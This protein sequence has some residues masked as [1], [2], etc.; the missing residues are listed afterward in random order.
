LVS[1]YHTRR[2]Q[3][4]PEIQG[5]TVADALEK[6]GEAF[7][8]D[9]RL[10]SDTIVFRNPQWPLDD[11]KEVPNRLLQRWDKLLKERGW[12]TLD[13]VAEVGA[14]TDDQ[15]GSLLIDRPEMRVVL[16]A[17]PFVR[18]YA[19]LSPGQRRA[20]RSPEGL[21][22]TQMRVADL[23]PLIEPTGNRLGLPDA[24]LW[25]RLG[26]Y[27]T[28]RFWA[29]EEVHA[30]RLNMRFRVERD[31]LAPQGMGVP[32]PTLPRGQDRDRREVPPAAASTPSRP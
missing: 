29:R 24:F 12:M 32:L 25:T 2:P 23:R 21:D 28:G 22:L 27:V 7:G 10:I 30:G 11:P 19:G 6:V 4:L 17:W 3:G 9:W 18:F 8:S 31:G 14:L 13:E 1:D 5:L 16:Q 15:L 26:R 20:A